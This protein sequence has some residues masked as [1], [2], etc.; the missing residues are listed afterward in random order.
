[1][2]ITYYIQS[3]LDSKLSQI[4]AFRPL[5]ENIVKKLRDQF[6]I[7]M[8]Y[9]SNA[10]EGNTLTLK[11]TFL[12][13]NEGITI[14]G[15]SLQDHLEAKDQKTALEFVY[16]L[17]DQHQ[18]VEISQNLIRELQ[19]LVIT[20]SNKDLARGYRT[21]SVT[22]TGSTHT[23]P[24]AISVPS[25][26]ANLI[27][28]YFQ[29]L[30]RIHPIELAAIFHHKLVYI[31]PFSDGNGRTARLIMNII[32]MQAGFP[33]T[34]ILKN[35]RAKYYRAL[36]KADSGNI[37]PFVDFIARSVERSLDIYLKALE[38]QTSV[39]QSLI[40]LSILAKNSPYSAKYLNLLVNLG[41]LEAQKRGRNWVSSQ[42]A[43]N[44]YISLISSRY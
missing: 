18:E 9:N 17:V 41:K 13:I 39:S 1:M 44:N 23:P 19:S 16:S 5:P 42:E 24:E 15:K 4:Q 12:V 43:L 28:W 8:A 20:N 21:T 2:S 25:E 3:R 22:I 32:L 34:I 40:P 31:H 10:I 27:Q 7:E 14:K 6:Q 33:L 26:M 29:N 36:D 35:D 37:T 38:P 30:S 11:E